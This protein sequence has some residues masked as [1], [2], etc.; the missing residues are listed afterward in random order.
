MAT[1]VLW[2][3]EDG[4]RI[5]R[6]SKTGQLEIKESSGTTRPADPV[7]DAAAIKDFEQNYE[8]KYGG[9]EKMDASL[10]TETYPV[11]SQ[12]GVPSAPTFSNKQASSGNSTSGSWVK[13]SD[14]FD[15]WSHN[16][17]T[18]QELPFMFEVWNPQTNTVEFEAVLPLNP[19]SYR[20]M[21]TPRATTTLTQGGVY[22]D[23]IGQAPPKFTLAGVFGVVGTTLV[24]AGKSLNKSGHTG[25][26]LYHEIEKALLEFY[27]RFGSYTMDG[28][29]NKNRVDMK[30][31]I[32][33][34]FYNFCDQEYWQVQI[35]QFSLQRSL[36]RRHLYQYDIQ[37]TGVKRLLE[38]KEDNILDAM[39]DT[40]PSA[41]GMATRLDAWDEFMKKMHGSINEI[42]GPLQTATAA[43]KKVTGEINRIKGMMW[44]ISDAV[45]DFK[46]GVTALIEA[47]FSLVKTALDV[48]TSINNSV[49]DIAKLPHEFVNDIRE[50]KRLLQRYAKQPNV[51]ALPTSKTSSA[52]A[53]DQEKNTEKPEITT[54]TLSD[55]AKTKTGTISLGIPEETIFSANME[56]LSPVA[57]RAKKI[58]D[59]ETLEDIAITNN[60]SWQQIALLNNIEYPYIANTDMQTLTPAKAISTTNII[61]N[62][63]DT[64]V[65]LS[66]IQANVGDI[67]T[68]DAGKTTYSVKEV[69]GETITLEEPISEQINPG[70]TVTVHDKKLSV[71][72]PGDQILLPGSGANINISKTTSDIESKLFGIDEYLNEQGQNKVDI[73]RDILT[74]SGYANLEMQLRHRI[75]TT[76]GELSGLGHPEYGSLVPTFIGKAN[77]PVWQERIMV[78]CMVAVMA[79][80]RVSKITNST[81]TIEGTAV[82]F[83]A[84]VRPIN[85]MQPI[86]IN[87]PIV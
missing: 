43:M 5:Q 42:T 62:T 32:E 3:A 52:A 70:A 33:L 22:E 30:T 20:M 53:T 10:G 45:A 72:R 74:V 79:D 36:Q 61:I 47:P 50:T 83:T 35:N 84:D 39:S 67:L 24:G 18:R 15:T 81:F 58:S 71:L 27:E 48:A 68:F 31:P 2:Q 80:P 64:S 51:F 65:P 7:A 16:G 86:Q 8:A 9:S 56:L 29:E 26:Y 17:Y 60:V 37:M 13:Q 55:A 4:K 28:N 78:E 63:G 1:G 44:Q 25:M 12:P 69:F 75:M 85:Q 38:N 19:E 76:K 57:S 54:I 34:R 82:Y 40:I 87:I 21:Y 59:G 11:A 23:I 73:G 46:N 41:E 66:V 14:L 6:S 49:S 77:T